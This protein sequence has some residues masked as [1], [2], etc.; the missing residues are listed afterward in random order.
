MLGFI[1]ADM[2]NEIFTGKKKPA[3]Y[4]IGVRVPTLLIARENCSA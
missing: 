3:V 1:I 2:F 4:P